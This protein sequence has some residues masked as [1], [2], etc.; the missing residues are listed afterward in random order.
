MRKPNAQSRTGHRRPPEV[1]RTTT[2]LS[3]AP[4]QKH[5]LGCCT[6]DMPPSK[7]HYFA[8]RYRVLSSA[9]PCEI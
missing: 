1:A 6:V 9:C 2:K 5:S 7:C 8:A 4:L 3:P